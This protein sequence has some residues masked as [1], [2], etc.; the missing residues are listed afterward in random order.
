MAYAIPKTDFAPHPEGRH[1]GIITHHEDKGMQQTPWGEKHK[2]AIYIESETATMDDGRAFLIVQWFTL[3]SDIRAGLRKFREA[4]LDRKLTDQ[5]AE[6]FD[7]DAELI[8]VRIRYRVDHTERDDG[9]TRANIREG[10][11]EPYVEE[12]KTQPASRTAPPQRQATPARPTGNGNRTAQRQPVAAGIQNDVPD[13]TDSD[14]P[15]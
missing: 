4:V 15:F 8:N 13:Q 1:T 7:A 11:V 10:S 3:S 5:E 2:I 9:S 14:I 12:P 6:V